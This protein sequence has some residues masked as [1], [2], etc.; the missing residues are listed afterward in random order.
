MY[1]L[2]EYFKAIRVINYNKQ[3]ISQY[4][5]PVIAKNEPYEVDQPVPPKLVYY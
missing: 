5:A 4:N 1:N 2:F 3:I